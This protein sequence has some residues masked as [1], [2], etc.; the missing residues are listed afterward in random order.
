MIGRLPCGYYD[1][2]GRRHREV[3]LCALSGRDE[4]MLASICGAP[5]ELVTDVLVRCLRRVGTVDRIDGEVARQLTVGDRQFL[6][7]KLREATFGPA[8][9]LVTSCSWPDCGERVDIEFQIS[10]VP[11]AE[12]DTGPIHRM[13]LSA[14]AL[15]GAEPDARSVLFRLPTGADQEDFGRLL[16]DNPAAAL[17]ALLRACVLSIGSDNPPSPERVAELS[18]LARAEVE[19]AMAA[20]A[21]GPVTTMRTRCPGCRREFDVP[22]DVA[23]LFFAEAGGSVDLLYRQV[24]YLA[25]HYHWGENEILSLPRAKRLRYV[26][27]LAEE[28]EGLNDALA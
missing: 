24:H 23:D 15:P 1:E 21:A 2:D 14:G 3:E 25:Y 19:R 11:V 10:D 26:E 4:E 7:L 5:A 13:E 16:E 22:L 9:A 6:M 17:H 27:L 20:A 8:V 18:P 12:S 28:I